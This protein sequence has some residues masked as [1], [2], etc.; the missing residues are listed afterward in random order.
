MGVCVEALEL[1]EA[2]RQD[3]QKHVGTEG[4]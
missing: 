1:A 2:R 4:G 3:L